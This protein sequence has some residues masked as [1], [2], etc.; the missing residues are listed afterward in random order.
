M[1]QGIRQELFIQICNRNPFTPGR[2]ERFRD[3]G[4]D[5]CSTVISLCSTEFLI[6][7]VA[8][9]P[10]APVTIATPGKRVGAILPIF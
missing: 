6:R 9:V 8:P 5:T 4:S 2:S 7:E 1:A 3:R 10:A